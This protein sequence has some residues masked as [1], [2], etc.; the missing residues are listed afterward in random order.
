MGYTV[1]GKQVSKPEKQKDELEEF[2]R[3]QNDPQWWRQI[4]DYLNNKDV[5]LSKGDLE[6]IKRM[7]EGAYAE[8][9]FNPE[10]EAFV[11]FDHP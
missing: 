11:E 7:R 10:Q 9:G 4:H 8:A 6:M 3:R 1:E 5:R 2:I